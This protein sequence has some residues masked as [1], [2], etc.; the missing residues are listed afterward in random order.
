MRLTS[1][2]LAMKLFIVVAIPFL[3]ALALTGYHLVL[4]WDA[5]SE[6]VKLRG[7][8]AGVAEISRLIHE[9][10]RER[11]ASAVFVGSRGEQ[12]RAELPKQR[13]LTDEQ[14]GTALDF[15]KELHAEATNDAMAA[16]IAAAR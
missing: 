4:K 5:R 11:G 1:L 16:G 10:Q 14:R 9:M 13:K 8:A 12:L 3:V 2:R 15:V 6:I 7:L